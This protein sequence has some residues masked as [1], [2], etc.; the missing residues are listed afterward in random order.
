MPDV[1]YHYD[2]TITPDR[3]KKFL[4]NAFEQCRRE[5]FPDIQSAFDGNKSCYTLKRLSSAIDHKVE[6]NGNLYFNR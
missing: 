1:A 3:P 5:K 6:V 2:V 4:R